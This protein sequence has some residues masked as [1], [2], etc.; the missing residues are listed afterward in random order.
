[1]VRKQSSWWTT[2]MGD[3]YNLRI[4]LYNYGCKAKGYCSHLFL[5]KK[6][7]IKG[8]AIHH[9]GNV[10]RT[11][12]FVIGKKHFSQLGHVPWDL[13]R[14][15][16]FSSCSFQ[17]FFLWKEDMCKYKERK[18]IYYTCWKMSLWLCYMKIFLKWDIKCMNHTFY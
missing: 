17:S 5:K 9:H 16:E 4:Q 1:M 2:K 12:L 8:V 10:D 11:S 15:R 14:Q 6:S 18:Y 3:W 7:L 13:K